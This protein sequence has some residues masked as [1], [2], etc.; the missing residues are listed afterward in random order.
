MHFRFRYLNFCYLLHCIVGISEASIHDLHY[1]K[2]YVVYYVPIDTGTI[3]DYIFH[4][5]DKTQL[6]KRQQSIIRYI[7]INMKIIN[8]IINII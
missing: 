2:L 5:F 6:D 7:N 8:N 1:V 3:L 4:R